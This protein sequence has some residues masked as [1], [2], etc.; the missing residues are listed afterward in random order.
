MVFCIE[1]ADSNDN[2]PVF[3]RY[4]VRIWA[5]TPT[6]KTKYLSGFHNLSREIRGVRLK[7]G[8]E[9]VRS[10]LFQLIIV[11]QQDTRESSLL[12]HHATSRKVVGSISD[13]VIGFIQQT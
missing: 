7:L 6:N 5:W 4:I 1:K 11:I 9:C 2:D 3:G 12:G 13:K 10:H 8:Y